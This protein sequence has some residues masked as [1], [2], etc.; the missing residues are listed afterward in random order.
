MYSIAIQTQY[1]YC[2]FVARTCR[3][4]VSPESTAFCGVFSQAI[5]MCGLVLT[6][7]WAS[8]RVMRT[9]SMPLPSTTQ[10]KFAHG[11]TLC[12]Q[13]DGCGVTDLGWPSPGAGHAAAVAHGGGAGDHQA[14]C[15][16]CIDPPLSVRYAQNTCTQ[17]LCCARLDACMLTPLPVRC[18]MFVQGEGS[19]YHL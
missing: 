13:A 2:T 17:R 9:E 4:A 6:K 3:C 18:K 19:A 1:M 11:Q 16:L 5:Q 15:I 12:L 10:V 14:E 7:V 8:Q